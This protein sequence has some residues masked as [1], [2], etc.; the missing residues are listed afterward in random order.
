M[1][2][3]AF[4]VPVPAFCPEYTTLFFDYPGKHLASL[5]SWVSNIP[6]GGQMKRFLLIAFFM[7]SMALLPLFSQEKVTEKVTIDW[8]VLP[9]FA[10]DKGGDAVLD[11]TGEDIDLRVNNQ[12]VTDFTLYKRVFS[13]DAV[14]A[15]PGEKEPLPQIE[16][17]KIVFLLFDLAFTTHTHYEQA[18][19]IA[20]NIVRKAEERTLFSIVAINPLKG[21]QYIAGPL[22]DKEQ[23]VRLIDEKITWDSRTKDVNIVLEMVWGHLVYGSA[24]GKGAAGGGGARLDGRDIA[25]LTEMISSGWRKANMHFYQSFQ[26][27]Y[28]ALNSI[29]DNKFIYLFSEGISLFARSAVVHGKEEY[30]YF[31]KKTAGYL[32][33]SGG[34]L[35]I[36]NPAGVRMNERSIFSG[37]QSLRYLAEESGGKYME[38][39]T[40]TITRRI[41]AMYRAYYEI[42]FPDRDSFKGETRQI[43]IASRRKGV[44]IHSLRS[45]EKNKRYSEMNNLEK[46]ILALNLSNPNEL[47][48]SPIKTRPLTIKDKFEKN[49]KIYYKIVLPRDFEQK[50]IDVFKISLIEGSTESRVEKETIITGKS[51]LT[52]EALKKEGVVPR[53]VLISENNRTALVQGFFDAEEEKKEILTGAAGDFM[54]KVKEMTLPDIR[55]LM[56]IKVGGAEYCSKLG[57]AVFHYICKET[58]S[59]RLEVIRTHKALKESEYDDRTGVYMQGLHNRRSNVRAVKRKVTNK[60]VNDYQLIGN[61]G[62]VTEQRKLLKGKIKKIAGKDELLRLDSF[63]TRKISLSPISLLGPENQAAYYYRFVKH[64]KLKGSDCAVLECFPKDVTNIESIYGEIWVDLT[65]FSIMRMNINPVSIGGYT[66]LLKLAKYYKAKLILSCEIDFFKKHK[67]IRFPTRVSIRETY[68]GGRELRSVVKKSV[69]ERSNT[70][71]TFDDYQFFEVEAASK[72]EMEK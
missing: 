27:L 6:V 14:T 4:W 23:V 2:G 64:D 13:V 72:E 59:E 34:V 61:K 21:P 68:S 8:W 7:C 51:P 24:R 50:S 37:E 15:Q 18:K 65:D 54:K 5:F 67:G 3:P 36:V 9:L 47:F 70:T 57:E 1:P 63:I 41:A 33:R 58:V 66:N 39:E 71:Y 29:K 48:Q 69:W 56:R 19:E 22:A 53:I 62:R 40:Q 38:G 31:M 55:E 16:K 42:A 28:H 12:K 30:W 44:N 60:Y 45:L 35:F 25:T 32:G 26:S 20:K 49:D 10:V 17:S 11:L 46:E 43:T 52:I